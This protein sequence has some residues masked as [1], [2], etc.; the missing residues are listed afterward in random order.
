MAITIAQI[1]TVLLKSGFSNVA[2]KSKDKEFV[3]I[4]SGESIYLN[5]A[6]PK[7][8]SQMIVHPR[9]QDKRAKLVN[10]RSG[11]GSSNDLIFGAGYRAFPEKIRNGKTPC[12][13]G[14]PFGFDS[15]VSL[16]VFLKEVFG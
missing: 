12:K 15:T 11:I 6:E 3:H 10:S 2:E 1:E 13:Y 14:V 7:V 8:Y 9:H 4:N 16:G 5:K